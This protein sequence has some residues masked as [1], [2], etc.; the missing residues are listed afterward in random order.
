MADISRGVIRNRQ[1]ATQIRDYS[2]LRYGNITP[3]DI[4][5]FVEFGDKL[6]VFIELKHK[7]APLPRGQ[8]LALERLT[9]AVGETG[10]TS[11]LLIAEHNTSGDIE[12]SQCKVIE[13]RYMKRWIIPHS[14]I[15]VREC[16]DEI[17]QQ[18]GIDLLPVKRMIGA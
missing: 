14:E 5:G 9:D 3:T 13:Y 4:D 15:T 18:A 7:D 8:R 17:L 2:G 10:R 16:V 6:F 12:T 1:Y 11:I